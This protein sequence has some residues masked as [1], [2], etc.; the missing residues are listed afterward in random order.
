M[1]IMEAPTLISP[2]YNEFH[3][4]SFSSEDTIAVVLLQIDEEGSEY[5]VAFF[6]KNLRDAKPRYDIIEKQAYALIK[7]LKDFRVYILHSKIIAY[8]PL[9]AI[10]YVL[11]QPDVDGRRAKW[12]SKMIKFN[13]ELK[14]TKL[15]R[16]QG[17]AK[18][19]AEENC[20]SLDIDFLC[21]TVENDQ[22]EEEKMAE[23]QRK[24]SVA[25]NLASCNWY[26]TIINFLL[27]L[28]IP[29]G[30]STSQVRT[31]KLRAT[32][33]CIYENLLYWRDQTRSNIS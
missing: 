10:K 15:V 9:A 13:I 30:L 5:L 33:Y 1:A 7:S 6:S 24:Q 3:I 14:S 27:K 11:T 17:L 26:A 20:R 18:L 31:L 28:E 12:I 19:L 25:Q 22:L 2:D 32:K 8:V 29:S 21:I 16:G 4:F 23:P